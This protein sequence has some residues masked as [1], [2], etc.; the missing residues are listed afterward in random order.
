M[1]ISGLYKELSVIILG[2]LP[3]SEV[4]GAIPTAIFA[5]QFPPW[6]AYILAVTGNIIA[7]LSVFI[8]LKYLSEFIVRRSNQ[9]KKIFSWLFEHT[10]KHHTG[11]FKRYKYSFWA[12]FIF[13]AMPLPL[14][15]A[16]SGA[17]AAVIFGMPPKVAALAIVSGVSVAGIIVII[18]SQAGNIF[19]AQNLF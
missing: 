18:L 6:K 1:E 10:K 13:I 2:A 5:Y 9:A 16:W 11:H 15:G 4:R 7:G 14:T 19:L 8:V 3:I 17:I 12:L